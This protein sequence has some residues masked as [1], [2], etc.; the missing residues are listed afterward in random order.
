MLRVRP[1]VL[2]VCYTLFGL[3]LRSASAAEDNHWKKDF[4]VKPEALKSTG[5]NEYFS[6]EPGDTL[7][8]EGKGDKLI[9]RVLDDT[10]EVDG[11]QTRVVEEHET[12]DGQLV[13]ISRNYFAVD[14]KTHDV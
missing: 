5:H 12:K 10:K 1:W 14:E 4:N 3:L 6:L 13:E 8:L 11:V 7:V 9:I 2:L